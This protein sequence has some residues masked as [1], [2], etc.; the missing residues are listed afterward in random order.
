MLQ[1]TVIYDRV[2]RRIFGPERN[3]VTG[4]RRKMC[5][6]ERS[7]IYS[8]PNIIRTIKSKRSKSV[9]HIFHIR[10]IRNT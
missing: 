2:L 7:N 10:K 5:N 8:S 6:E 4:E 9:G 1:A 3:K